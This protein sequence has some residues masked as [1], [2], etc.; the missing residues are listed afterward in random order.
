MEPN[1]Q[2]DAP[3][4]LEGN[5]LSQDRIWESSSTA[6][7]IRQLCDAEVEIANLLRM[8]ASVMKLLAL[9]DPQAQL[10]G[11][12]VNGD[13]ESQAP[14]EPTPSEMLAHKEATATGEERG[15]LLVER[16]GQ[17]YDTLDLIQHVL[18]RSLYDLRQRKISPTSITAPPPDFVPPALGVGP[19]RHAT[20]T[21]GLE[22]R[23]TDRQ[24]LQE[25]RVERAAWLGVVNAL[26]NLK[27]LRE[28]SQSDTPMEDAEV[29]SSL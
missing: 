6:K 29:N 26:E 23:E 20:T 18:R 2:P 15:E 16:V 9:P 8:A 13:G 12:T 11:N 22:E 21:G 27:R 4:A 14:N 19:S 28:G 25:T 10:P 1:F 7:Q 3:V 24:G 5:D 17:Y